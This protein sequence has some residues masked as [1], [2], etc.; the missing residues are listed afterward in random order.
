MIYKLSFISFLIIGNLTNVL[1]FYPN[2]YASFLKGNDYTL[3]DIT[4]IG[5]LQAV[6]TYFE[7]VPPPGSSTNVPAGSL[8]GIT[9]ITARKLYDAYYGNSSSE[10]RFQEAIND[11]V[12]QN[13]K[14][15][16]EHYREAVWYVNGEQI[17]QAH[18]LLN[19]LR[20]SLLQ[21]LGASTPSYERARELVGQYLHIIQSFYSN[22]NWVELH[23]NGA[24][25]EDY[26]LPGKTLTN[27]AALST[28][29]C[30]SCGSSVGFPC[31]INM[32]TS[33][34]ELT[35]GY[36]DGQDIQKPYKDPATDNKGKC[37]HGGLHDKSADTIAA[38]GGINKDTKDPTLSPHFANHDACGT[39]SHLNGLLQAV[40]NT[41]FEEL[42]Q[43][44]PGNSLVFVI[45]TS[46]S[47]GS[48]VSAVKSKTQEIIN[49]TKG[50]GLQPYNYILVTFSDPES[51]TT[52]QESTNPNDI[53]NW[54]NA[55]QVSGGGD[56]PEYIMSEDPATDNKGKCSHGGLHDKS[57]DTIAALGGI[58]KDTKDPT[59]SPHF[60]IHDAAGLAAIAH[61]KYFLSDPVNGLLQAVG[62]THFEELFQ[63]RPGNSLVFV[64]DTSGSMGSVVSAVKSKTQEII[65]LTKGTGLQ[66]YNYILVTFSDPESATTVQEST[67]P[68]DIV[69]WVNAIQV[70]GGGDCPEYIMSGI[71]AAV[72]KA[73]PNSHVYVFTDATAKDPEKQQYILS[74]VSEK[75]LHIDF[76]VTG[77]CDNSNAHFVQ[78]RSVDAQMLQSNGQSQQADHHYDDMTGKMLAI[79]KRHSKPGKTS[80]RDV[81]TVLQRT[82]G[83]DDPSLVQIPVDTYLFSIVIRIDGDVGTPLLAIQ[84][85]NGSYV[86]LDGIEASGNQLAG[87]TLEMTITNPTPGIW[88]I[89]RLDKSDWKLKVSGESLVTFSFKLHK[90]ALLEMKEYIH[91][92]QTDSLSDISVDVK[93]GSVDEVS[94]SEV[95]FNDEYGD[96]IS[97]SLLTSVNGSIN[98]KSYL[99][100]VFLPGEKYRVAIEGLDNKG[101]N[102]RREK[103]RLYSH[104]GKRSTSMAHR[105]SRRSTPTSWSGIDYYTWIAQASG[106]HVFHTTTSNIGTTTD[107]LKNSLSNS[108]VTIIRD[109]IKGGST[110]C[111]SINVPIDRT[112][113]SFKVKVQGDNGL[114]VPHVSRPDGS[115]AGI[116]GVTATKQVI[117]SNYV[118]LTYMYPQPG[119][120]V[121]RRQDVYGWDIEVTAESEVDFVQSFLELGPDGLNMFEIKGRPIAGDNMTI[122]I[123][124]H[125]FVNITSLDNLVFL[126]K[127]GDEISRY[128]LQTKSAQRGRGVFSTTAIIP[129][130]AFQVAVDGEDDL[131]NTFRRVHTSLIN[132][133]AIKL[134]DLPVQ[135]PFYLDEKLEIPYIITNVGGGTSMVNITISDDQNLAIRPTSQVI[136]LMS[137]ENSTS[138]FSMYADSGRVAVGTTTTITITAQPMGIIGAGFQF[139]IVR[140]TTEKRT[141]PK[142]DTIPPHCEV[143]PNIQGVCG[144]DECL[145]GQTFI[146][147]DFTLWDEGEGLAQ[148]DPVGIG[149]GNFSHTPF[150][151]GD[152]KDNNTVNGTIRVDCCRKTVYINVVDNAS[153]PTQCKIEVNPTYQNKGCNKTTI[154]TTP[155]HCG[156]LTNI[157][158]ICGTDDCL[159]SQTTVIANFEIWDI[160][161][162]LSTIDALGIGNG[163]FTHTP[164]VKGDVKANN[165]VD[166]TL[167][168]DCCRTTV[169]VNVM[170]MAGL[171]G[172][173]V[174]DINPGYT[175][176]KNNKHIDTTP[177]NC[178]LLNIQGTCGTDDCTCHQSSVTSDVQLY[179]VG[180]GLSTIH[181]VG[182]GTGSFTHT[183]FTKGD[184]LN[185]NIV[186]GTISVDCCREEVYVNV[187]DEAGLPAQCILPVNQNYTGCV[188]TTPTPT[189]STTV[190]TTSSST[191]SVSSA[192]SN[193]ASS[194]VSNSGS[195]TMSGAQSSTSSGA[196][197]A[198]TSSPTATGATKS[199]TQSSGGNDDGNEEVSAIAVA[200]I[201][202]GAGMVGVAFVAAGAYLIK[203][204]FYASV[205]PA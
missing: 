30:Q 166:A 56:C 7:G 144:S 158:G 45:D 81:V 39:G 147:A 117:G 9:D 71:K 28:D 162:G 159:C 14:V 125:N 34:K 97:S 63:L 99:G 78:R 47:M 116:N 100:R 77:S 89:Y 16:Q 152:T 196:T 53:V 154:D 194:S 6:A 201:G 204:K 95:T 32:M 51:A 124:V 40:G 13:T 151:I 169:F 188:I 52:V 197:S 104:V 36:R 19:Q 21:V 20:D 189:T 172:Q 107:V 110:G 149:S 70:S 108:E 61:T 17:P 76:V 35:S 41:H 170:D 92:S 121:I 96:V 27:L 186:N 22:T 174:V 136:S 38:L 68:N 203:L 191:N 69:N 103:E 66:P 195:S 131:A 192:V 55:I 10:T 11:L 75:N 3:A 115:T 179:D 54:V 173:C 26:G 171:P 109:I 182:L 67:N 118:V 80:D 139:V 1:G 145:C 37:S 62:N 132:T 86:T 167:S 105:R 88:Q 165:T 58:N 161:D 120:W 102:L 127:Y 87:N 65:N 123:V 175:G 112:C 156:N 74:I 138:H 25:Y 199:A 185:T 31:F 130:Q 94:V 79:S 176:C 134:E 126:D 168:V 140:L 180:D 33:P 177:P 200:G 5:V 202:L 181:A 60:A 129:D 59:L 18:T 72:V 198:T 119:T 190:N 160:G 142:F 183:A 12:K 113:K 101:F 57:A 43:L 98:Q 163:T 8:T 85:P 83:Y 114:P 157:Q 141:K 155:P 42:F 49:L 82:V 135:N 4:E 2:Q 193:S 23:S 150:V 187:V 122:S 91:S 184:T 29:M 84:K 15:D 137:G 128:Q 153:L 133:V 46:G 48:V 146:S 90:S 44:R 178:T 24:I 111:A 205:A 148:V 143:H 164:F 73:K 93:S 106:G 50:T 64:I